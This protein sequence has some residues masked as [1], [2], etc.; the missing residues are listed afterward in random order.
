MPGILASDGDAWA[1][2]DQHIGRLDEALSWW[3]RD[4]ADGLGEE[5]FPPEYPKMP[6]E[7]PRVQP[8]KKKRADSEYDSPM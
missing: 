8:S 2:I 3:E 4:V 6:G 1:G 7:P 5:P